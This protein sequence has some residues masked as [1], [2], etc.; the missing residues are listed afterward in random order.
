MNLFLL[1]FVS[2]KAFAIKI[3]CIK[4][5]LNDGAFSEIVFISSSTKRESPVISEL[6]SSKIENENPSR[7]KKSWNSAS[8]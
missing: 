8:D 5:G 3:G 4:F 1:I 7:L 2:K 6:A